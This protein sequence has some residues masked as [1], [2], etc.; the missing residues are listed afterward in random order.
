[1][2]SIEQQLT[3]ILKTLPAP[4]QE[5]LLE[6]A[7]FLQQ[8]HGIVEDDVI[9]EP[10][11]IPR[12]EQEN[13][14]NAIRRLS[15]NY[16]MLDTSKFFHEASS[17]MTQHIMQGRDPVMVID[18]LEELFAREYGKYKTGLRTED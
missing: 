4:Q 14:I 6:Y 11:A 7:E 10:K 13:V 16:F 17:L 3:A 18:D 8:K 15:D 12:P 5:L 9:H 2:P 1:M